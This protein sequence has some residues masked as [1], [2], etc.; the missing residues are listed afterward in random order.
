MAATYLIDSNAIIDYLG[1]KLSH[2]G[3]LFMNQ[4]VD[5]VPQVSIITQI[6]VLGFKTSENVYQ[7]LTDFFADT[8]VFILDQD[9]A[10]RTVELRMN[11]NIKLPDA[12]IAATALVNGLDLITRNVSDFQKIP[13]LALLNPHLI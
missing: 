3:M 5:N 7:I 13:H 6:E 10:K 2:S 4:V 1:G 12:I 11:H 9:V 8:N